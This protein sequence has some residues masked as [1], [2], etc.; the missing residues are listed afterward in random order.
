MGVLMISARGSA[1]DTPVTDGLY[2][3]SPMC[4]GVQADVMSLQ[5]GR[6]DKCYENQETLLT[7][8]AVYRGLNHDSIKT[9]YGHYDSTYGSG[10][11]QPAIIGQLD[12]GSVWFVTK[13]ECI[14]LMRDKKHFALKLIEK[15]CKK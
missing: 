11:R 6:L 13:D 10:V 15:H 2:L 12:D 14:R 5:E 4:P 7:A 9:V 1:T 3:D 8:R